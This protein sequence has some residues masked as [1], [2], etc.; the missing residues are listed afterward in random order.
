MAT[1]KK[2]KKPALVSNHPAT[3]FL[4]AVYHNNLRILLPKETD[5]YEKFEDMHQEGKAERSP[6]TYL[7]TD[8]IAKFMYSHFDINRISNELAQ[9]IKNCA[10]LT[11]VAVGWKQYQQV[12]NFHPALLEELFNIDI[13]DDKYAT[14]SRDEIPYLPCHNFYVELP[15]TIKEKSFIGFF[16]FFDHINEADQF[17]QI[18]IVLLNDTLYQAPRMKNNG[19]WAWLDYYTISLVY[20]YDKFRIY[21]QE[22]DEVYE[23]D[24]SPKEILRMYNP[25]TFEELGDDGAMELLTHITQ[26]ITYLCATNADFVRTKKPTKKSDI[27]RTRVTDLEYE[28][29]SIGSQLYN[30]RQVEN[31]LL[32]TVNGAY[33]RERPITEEVDTDTPNEQSELYR[34]KVGYHVRPHMR[35]AHWKYYWYGKKDGSEERVKRRKFVSAVFINAHD[36]D[37]QTPTREIIKYHF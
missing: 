19:Y 36:E 4:N 32:N 5:F 12:Y 37:I 28:K 17:D 20:D 22:T 30:G 2:T 14:I 21:S 16:V 9:E 15:I 6:Y 29:W 7:T 8:E 24:S 26:V 33:E 11:A 3:E 35:R 27:K 34:K 31:R 13:A 18:R 1:K 10:F 23:I 25:R